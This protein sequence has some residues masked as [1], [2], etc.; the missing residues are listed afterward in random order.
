MRS[1]PR[2]R[3]FHRAA[4]RAR[5]CGVGGERVVEGTHVFINTGTYVAIPNVP[6]L[7]DAQPMTHVEALALEHLPEHLIV[8]GGG[9]IGLEMAQAFRRLG[10]KVTVLQE[11]AR[12]A[13]RE[14]T[15]VTDE[16]EAAFREEGIDVRVSVQMTR[17]RPLGAIVNVDLADGTRVS[18][19]EILCDGPHFAHA[20]HWDGRGRCRTRGAWLRERGRA[21]LD[22][23]R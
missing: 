12:V 11:A 5:R 8:V 2:Y 23:S 6:G 9:Y 4:Y 19:T 13:M 20:A 1:D 16:I 14:G 17:Q 22:V 18:G 3:Q 21:T 15:D 7:R 10:S